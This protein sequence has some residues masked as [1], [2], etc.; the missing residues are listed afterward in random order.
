M[1]I[2]VNDAEQSEKFSGHLAIFCLF[3][4]IYVS[5]ECLDQGQSPWQLTKQQGVSGS[6]TH[7]LISVCV[8]VITGMT[9]VMTPDKTTQAITTF[10]SCAEP[11]KACH[12]QTAPFSIIV[13]LL[14]RAERILPESARQKEQFTIAN[15]HGPSSGSEAERVLWVTGRA[16]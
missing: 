12:Q 9:H 6:T 4:S 3:S 8:C 1:N 16:I 15:R 10:Q 5:C 11:V 14:T 7:C 2:V 13:S